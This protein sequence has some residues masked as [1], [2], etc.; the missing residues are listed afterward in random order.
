[1]VEANGAEWRAWYELYVQRLGGLALT[2]KQAENLMQMAAT[3]EAEPEQEHLGHCAVC[4]VAL[5]PGGAV[6]I[7]RRYCS[8][9]CRQR[10]YRQRR[11]EG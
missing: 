4:D 3:D 8:D 10:A 7:S 5:R 11:S 2:R 6:R 1:L 9:A